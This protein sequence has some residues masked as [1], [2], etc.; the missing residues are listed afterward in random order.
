MFGVDE[1]TAALALGYGSLYNHASVGNNAK[2]EHASR[3]TFRFLATKPIAVGEEILVT[4][5]PEWWKSRGVDP[6]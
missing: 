2:Y 5:G 6:N 1:D 4:Y 3:Y